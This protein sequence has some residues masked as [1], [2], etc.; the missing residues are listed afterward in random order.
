MEAPLTEVHLAE[1]SPDGD[2]NYG[3][4]FWWEAPLASSIWRRSIWPGPSDQGPSGGGPSG[5]DL[6]G[7][8]SSDFPGWW[9]LLNPIPGGL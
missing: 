1:A 9:A 8:G 4:P 2:V 6:S 7:R 3:R 5:E